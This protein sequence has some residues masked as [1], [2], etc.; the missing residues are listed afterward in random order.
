MSKKFKL[1]IIPS[2]FSTLSY[3]IDLNNTEQILEHAIE[4]TQPLGVEINEAIKT[5][6]T[7]SIPRSQIS[8][9]EN[10]LTKIE[11]NS[12]KKIEIVSEEKGDFNSGKNIFKYVLKDDCNMTGHKFS[13]QYTQEEWEEI[14]ELN[15]IKDTIFESCP[16]VKNYYQDKWTIDLYNFFHEMS[17]D[18]DGIPEC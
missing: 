6:V 1:L 3:A 7:T 15:T 8:M 14:A 17:N 5:I 9:D 2:L 4:V 18:E 16:N 13:T 12:T 11:N 10:N